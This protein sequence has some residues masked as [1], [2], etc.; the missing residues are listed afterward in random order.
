[1]TVPAP[2]QTVLIMDSERQCSWC[3]DTGLMRYPNERGG[4]TAE[5]CPYCLSYE[6]KWG[7]E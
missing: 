2:H 3:H 5:R 7:S 6:K 1:M 4:T